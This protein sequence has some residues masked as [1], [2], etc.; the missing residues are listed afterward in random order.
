MS[1]VDAE[2]ADPVQRALQEPARSRVRIQRVL[3]YHR[4][5]RDYRTV[6]ARDVQEALDAAPEQV[7]VVVRG[8]WGL[9]HVR[10]LEDGGRRP[11]RNW[12]YSFVHERTPGF[13]PERVEDASARD[14]R[15]LVDGR[16]IQ[17]KPLGASAFGSIGREDLVRLHRRRVE[18]WEASDE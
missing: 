1:S 7:A 14:V 4:G 2:P 13:D 16:K 15:Q 6:K 9:L 10:R 17:V 8:S 12:S 11:Y 3:E 18:S 5:E